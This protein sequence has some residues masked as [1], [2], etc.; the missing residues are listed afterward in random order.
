MRIRQVGTNGGQ[1]G[2]PSARSVPRQARGTSEGSS[3][4]RFVP[5]P[6]S[7]DVLRV[8][9]FLFI[10]ISISTVQGYVRPLG[11]LRPGITLWVLALA[12]VFL[13]PRGVRW[14]NIVASF[15]PKAVGILVVLACLSAPFGLSLGASGN[16]LLTVY[17]RIVVLFFILVIAIRSVT[18]LRLFVWAFVLASGILALLALTVMEVSAGHG[19]TRV[20]ASSMYDAND[21]GMIFLTAIPL[22]LLL[23][24]TSGSRARLVLIAALACISG[25]IAITGSRGAFVGFVFVLPMLFLAM[26]HVSVSRRI[27]FVLALVLGLV[28][29]APE[30]YWDRISTII[31]VTDDYNVKDD[32]GRV[33]VSKRGVGYMLAYPFGVGV[34]N[35]PRAEFTISPLARA[36]APGEPVR[37]IAPHNTYVQVGAEM[38]LLALMTWLSM[39]WAGTVGLWSIRRRARRL[40]RHPR[41]GYDELFVARCTAYVPIAFI[42]FAVTS[43]F[44]SHAYTPV[45][46]VIVAI[47]SG[48]FVQHRRHRREAERGITAGIHAPAPMGPL[49]RQRH[50]IVGTEARR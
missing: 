26:A 29:G 33:E 35:F 9:L 49:A 17:F 4:S 31:N 2:T 50:A 25:A 1:S 12:A 44:V 24:E 39:L 48:I 46:Y 8:S 42:G 14:S 38:G 19:G 43:Y 13:V 37:M 5:P 32:Y 40:A 16:F 15:P 3:S 27:G 10:I 23:F 11:L 20:A 22:A 41:A 18:D 34:D 47:L 6:F 45:F 36:A 7:L 28:V 30:G 21:L